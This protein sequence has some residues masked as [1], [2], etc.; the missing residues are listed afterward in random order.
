M[1]KDRILHHLKHPGMMIPLQIPTNCGFQQCL[2]SG[3]VEMDFA[4]NST[5]WVPDGA[6]EV[7]PYRGSI[8]GFSGA[9]GVAGLAA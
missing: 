4:T 9:A 8:R 5:H 2:Q 6:C 1:A 3:A 7:S